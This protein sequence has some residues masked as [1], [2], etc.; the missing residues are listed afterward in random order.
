M[1][2]LHLSTWKERCGI[3]DFTESVVEHLAE[4][5]VE[6][7]V[8]PLDVAS[9]RYA[10][11][12]ELLGELD[13][14]ARRAADFDVV[15]VQHEFSLFTGSG[16]IFDTL[17]NFARLLESLEAENRPVVVTFHSGAAL[18]SLLPVPQA[19]QTRGGPNGAAAFLRSAITRI[20]IDRAARKLE[21]IWRRRIA[22]FFDGKRRFR[23][24]V[25]TRR[26]RLEMLNSGFA[27][28]SVSVVP[29]GYQLRGEAF[30][31]L[32]RDEARDQLGIPRDRLLLTM[33]GFVG[34]YKGHLVAVQALKK[35]P[36]NYHLAI[37]GGP[38]P[39]NPAD[40]TLNSLLEIWEGED[41]ARLTVSGYVSR[42][43][44][45]LYHAA[46]DICLAPFVQGNPTG[47]A[48]L[49][50]AL[51]SGKPTIASNIPA[52]AEIQ[53]A[54]DC[55]LLCTPNAVHELAWQIQQLARNSTLQQK[56][57]R[58][59]LRFAADNN[60]TRVADRLKDIYQEVQQ[61]TEHSGGNVAAA[62]AGGG[63]LNWA[64]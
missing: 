6:N 43:S 63:G 55:L 1:R 53:R 58:N 23:A 42:E 30:F 21:R 25:H 47:S 61:A 16:G 62:T 31:S 38:H 8:F 56:L 10:T 41:P 13:R 9:L 50:W 4:L 18:R 60:W 36:P 44:I 29:L 5:G 34:A 27:P 26:T 7:E 59:A 12:A 46:T 51:T 54:G 17:L 37:V 2:V 19:D 64:A 52:F 11:S 39:L 57:A 20:R 15:H 45:D 28:E 22:P 14:F 32:D 35:L 40:Q 48:S 49:S 33:F 24:L 3:A